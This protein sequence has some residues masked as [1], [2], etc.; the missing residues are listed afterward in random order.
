M[1][2]DKP[3]PEELDTFLKGLSEEDLIELIVS[4]AHHDNRVPVE[5]VSKSNGTRCGIDNDGHRLA[6][7]E[8]GDR[9]KKFF[10]TLGLK[11]LDP[12]REGGDNRVMN[13]LKVNAVAAGMDDNPLRFRRQYFAERLS[14]P[15]VAGLD[16]GPLGIPEPL[17]RG[18]LQLAVE[19]SRMLRGVQ[20]PRRV[21]ATER[22]EKFV[23][24]LPVHELFEVGDLIVNNT[25]HRG[26][27]SYRSLALEQEERIFHTDLPFIYNE[28]KSRVK[29]M[30][31]VK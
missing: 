23:K 29:C 10:D 4:R 27:G 31:E 17:T 16:K 18:D 2:T 13:L 20:P 15:I 30:P 19:H 8:Q 9:A 6:I 21:T 22:F 14:R 3:T 5:F 25:A 28:I 11:L 7:K 24:G 12:T 26:I 1:I